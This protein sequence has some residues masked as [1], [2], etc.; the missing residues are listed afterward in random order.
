MASADVLADCRDRIHAELAYPGR[1]RQVFMRLPVPWPLCRT[2]PGGLAAEPRGAASLTVPGADNTDAPLYRAAK[3]WKARAASV[4]SELLDARDP[5]CPAQTWE[6]SDP[7]INSC[8]GRVP[9]DADG[10]IPLAGLNLDRCCVG[11]CRSLSVMPLKVS[12]SSRRRH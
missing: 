12:P 7:K 8:R 9:G 10:P 2:I 4:S 6:L 11:P 1:R 5:K 3:S